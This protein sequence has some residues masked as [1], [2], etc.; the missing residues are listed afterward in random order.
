M[1]FPFSTTIVYLCT[2]QYREPGQGTPSHPTPD[3]I[4]TKPRKHLTM[5]TFLCFANI[6]PAKTIH[7]CIDPAIF[8]YGTAAFITL[9]AVLYTVIIHPVD[10]QF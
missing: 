9:Y 4:V 5:G 7:F 2:E 6:A 8:L 1:Q 3:R 10:P